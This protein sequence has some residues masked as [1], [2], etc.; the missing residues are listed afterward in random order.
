ML[1]VTQIL[2]V[3]T[4]IPLLLLVNACGAISPIDMNFLVVISGGGLF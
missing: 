4:N 1:V 3:H 2:M